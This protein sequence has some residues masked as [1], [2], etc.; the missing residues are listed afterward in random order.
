MA[1]DKLHPI[2][3]RVADLDMVRLLSDEGV[4]EA[5]AVVD[6][7]IRRFLRVELSGADRAVL[8]DFLRDELG[9]DRI[10]SDTPQTEA[11]LRALLYLILSTPEYQLA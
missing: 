7:L 3:R 6:H 5:G 8:V 4:S 1:F 9:G 10:E 2:P 11:A